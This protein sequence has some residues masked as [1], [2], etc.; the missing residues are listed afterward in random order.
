MDSRGGETV[1]DLVLGT[2]A[3]YSP[4]REIGSVVGDEAMRK[5][6]AAHDVLSEEFDNLLSCDIRERHC[7]HPLSEVVSGNQQKSELRLCMG[8]KTYCVKPPLHEGQGLHRA[9][10]SILGLFED[11]MNL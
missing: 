10:R 4:A 2:E 6:E 7:F 8:K 9:W 3:R 1:G 5:P 11:G